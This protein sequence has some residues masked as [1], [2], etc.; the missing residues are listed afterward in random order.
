MS[1]HRSN[2]FQTTRW[3]LLRGATSPEEKISEEALA[4]FCRIYRGPLLAFAR[5]TVPDPQDAEDYIQGFFEKLLRRG[6]L[7]TADPDRGKLRTFLLTCLK[8]HITDELRKKSAGMRGGGI[9][10]VPIG[11]ARSVASREPAPDDIY[12]RQWVLLLLERTL[13]NLRESWEKDGKA[14]LFDALKPSLGFSHEVEADRTALAARL[15]M[16]TGNLKTT[17]YRLRKEY[18]ENL[19]AEISSTLEDKSPGKVMDEMRSLFA[20]V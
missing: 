7:A 18:R 3:S 20:L 8:R 13:A 9:S 17:I 12:H 15:G 16:S 1:E 6:F 5:A 4:E 10:E 11:E 2:R 19:M 14:G